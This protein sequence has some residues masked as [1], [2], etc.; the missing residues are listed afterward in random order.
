[1]PLPGTS[2][3]FIGPRLSSDPNIAPPLLAGSSR[4]TKNRLE[5]MPLV[6]PKPP[7]KTAT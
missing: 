2:A 7:G 1:M 3:I 4:S 5:P 6:A